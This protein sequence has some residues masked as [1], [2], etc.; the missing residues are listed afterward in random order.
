MDGL[1]VESAVESGSE[2]SIYYDPMIAK[3]IVHDDTREGAMRKMGSV[4]DNMVCL[5]TITNQEFLK[6]LVRNEG[7]IQG[8]YNTHFLA[9]QFKLVD[10]TA[11][12]QAHFLIA[13]AL[14]LHQE[15]NKTNFF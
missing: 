9:E 6:Q 13:A 8:K 12:H 10:Q 1:R 7:V 3:I 11:Q 2:I 5:G 15:R 14:K 4:L